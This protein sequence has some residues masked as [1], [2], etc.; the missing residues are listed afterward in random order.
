MPRTTPRRL[1]AT[2]EAR[3]RQLM[4]WPGAEEGCIEYGAEHPTKATL[5]QSDHGGVPLLGRVGNAF[6]NCG[7]VV[8]PLQRVPSMSTASVG[9]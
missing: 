9:C 2:I 7:M 4:L 3:N 6:L 5:S 8:Y 1:T